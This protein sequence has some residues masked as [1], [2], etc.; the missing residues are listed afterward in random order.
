M[1]SVR[2][3]VYE[4]DE[5]SCQYCGKDDRSQLTLEHL[6]PVSQGG[7]DDILNFVTACRSC[8]SSKQ[9]KD[10]TD[11]LEQ[12]DEVD[13]DVSDLPVHGDIILDTPELPKAYRQIRRETFWH[14]RES[15]KL[16]GSTAYKELEKEFRRSLWE[17][18]FGKILIY[19]YPRIP[20]NARASIPLVEQ[21]VPDTRVP[22][23]R[24]LVEFCKSAS[25]R[26]L[27]DEAIRRIDEKIE[28]YGLEAIRDTIVGVREEGTSTQ[29]RVVQAFE[30]ANVN[31]LNE[32]AFCVP[33][34][35]ADVPIAP[36]DLL[37]VDIKEVGGRLQG[38][39]N[40]YPIMGNEL[41]SGERIPVRI[42]DT[43]P[44]CA[45]AISLDQQWLPPKVEFDPEIL[46]KHGSH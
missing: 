43:K 42:L 2:E 31:K 12:H 24:V 15:G 28:V 8:N 37:F 40:D 9:A 36:R 3:E 13:L 10:L 38:A 23:H 30:R 29:K 34:K 32:D 26:R 44:D 17:S 33:E 25:T 11:F 22:M 16:S 20:G 4:R 18:D 1:E 14:F 5:Y 21:L 27:I 41:T 6:A 45:R 46:P 35:I 39:V 19:R 7:I